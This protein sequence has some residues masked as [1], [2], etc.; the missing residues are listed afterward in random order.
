MCKYRDVLNINTFIFA[1]AA[2]IKFSLKLE[3]TGAWNLAI[4]IMNQ[5]E[6]YILNTPRGRAVMGE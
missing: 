2:Q 4:W 5:K 6:G 3:E 1:E